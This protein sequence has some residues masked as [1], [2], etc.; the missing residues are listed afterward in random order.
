MKNKLFIN[1][2]LLK[3]I[4]LI[5]M[6]INHIGVFLESSNATLS[7][8]LKSIGIIAF[9]IFLFLNIEGSKNT[10]SNIAYI[11]RLLIMVIA[12]YIPITIFSNVNTKYSIYKFGNIFVD[13]CLYSIIY[14]LLFKS[15]KQYLKYIF[16]PIIFIY[17]IITHLIKI[18]VISIDES[19]Y[20][21]IGGLFPQY[22]L[23]GLLIFIT[24][25]ISFYIYE[26]KCKKI[27]PSFINS[28]KYYFSLNIIYCIILAI[29]SFI[30]YAFTYVDKNIL[31]VDNVLSTYLVVSSIFIIFYNHT[32]YISKNSNIIK[33]LYYLYYP[34]H[35]VILYLIFAL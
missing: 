15:N 5:L 35:L 9:P 8:I 31:G 2:D 21:Y 29:F 23:F 6:T 4:G 34:L 18:D 13:L 32:R 16:I 25:I 1:N 27:D 11:L 22:N 30:S 28:N 20:K 33:Y 12:I 3:I 14:Y 7:L 19:L 24:S 10:R 17:F 26:S